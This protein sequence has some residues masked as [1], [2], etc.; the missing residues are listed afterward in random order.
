MAQL[1]EE[2]TAK[3]TEVLKYCA[4][5]LKEFKDLPT[6]RQLADKFFL[7][8]HTIDVHFRHIYEKLLVN[9]KISALIAKSFINIS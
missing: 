7:S 5:Y 9:S 1:T 2:L 4:D 3:E 8:I 6:N